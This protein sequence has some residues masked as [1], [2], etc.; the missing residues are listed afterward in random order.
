[1]ACFY[2][3]LILERN[4]CRHFSIFEVI[5]LK[6]YSFVI[7]THLIILNSVTSCMFKA[8]TPLCVCSNC[9]LLRDVNMLTKWCNNVQSPL[10]SFFSTSHSPVFSS[11]RK[12]AP[13]PLFTADKDCEIWMKALKASKWMRLFCHTL[14]PKSRMSFHYL[15]K[16]S[17]LDINDW[18]LVILYCD[19][20][21]LNL[22]FQF[23]N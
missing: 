3:T 7:N 4:C 1:M 19:D 6:Q 20:M 23:Q 15:S 22:Y 12:P 2:S 13:E 10:T 9:E 18:P 17:F 16:G 21:I 11:R 14:M 8:C 5:L